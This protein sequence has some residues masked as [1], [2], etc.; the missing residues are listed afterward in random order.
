[1]KLY[2]TKSYVRLEFE[3]FKCQ[4]TFNGFV[5]LTKSNISIGSAI[6]FISSMLCNKLNQ[7]FAFTYDKF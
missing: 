7:Y 3:R 5:S 1:M 4:Q 6:S 2:K